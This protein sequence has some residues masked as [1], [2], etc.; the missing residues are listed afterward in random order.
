MI[1]PDRRTFPF[2]IAVAAV[3]GLLLFAAAESRAA[4]D[5][6]CSTEWNNSSASDSCTT[7]SIYADGDDCVIYY[8]CTK[9][10]GH[11]SGSQSI[12]SALGSVSG[13]NNCNGSLWWN[14]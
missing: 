10:N 8:S 13:L 5:A 7:S 14:C 1:D 11:S 9:S 3:C 2:L 4:T 12:T 6:Q